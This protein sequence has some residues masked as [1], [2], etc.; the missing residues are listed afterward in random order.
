MKIAATTVV[1]LLAS[2]CDAFTAPHPGMASATKSRFASPSSLSFAP[3]GV[4]TTE[5]TNAMDFLELNAATLAPEDLENSLWEKFSKWITSTEVSVTRRSFV[6]SL[7]MYQ[8]MVHSSFT[9]HFHLYRTVST[10]A[11]LELLCSPPC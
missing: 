10:L 5:K 4:S 2:T 11:G 9:F 6:R 3:K 8:D 1:A 7:G